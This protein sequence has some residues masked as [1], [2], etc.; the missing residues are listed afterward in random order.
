MAS[1]D[2]DVRA[3]EVQHRQAEGGAL[4]AKSLLELFLHQGAEAGCQRIAQESSRVKLAMLMQIGRALQE[5]GLHG[6]AIALY[7]SI[8][9]HFPDFAKAYEALGDLY[10]YTLS[11]KPKARVAYQSALAALPRDVT[12]STP[13]Q[14]YLRY[15][16]NEDI[17]ALT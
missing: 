17:E 15:S 6:E 16:L 2:Q 11:D 13:E 4:P 7:Q 1:L 8:N 12:L 10:H 5:R 3:L 9:Q 14:D